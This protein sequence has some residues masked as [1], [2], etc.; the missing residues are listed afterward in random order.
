MRHFDH[1]YAMT[2]HS[3]QGITTDRVLINVDTKSSADL[4]G[5]RFAYVAV[6]RASQDAQV[7]TNDAADVGQRL[8]REASNSSAVEFGRP[9][10]PE[11]HTDLAI[12]L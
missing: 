7:F 2:S 3:A 6:S 11:K 1:G 12:S 5:T 8:S 10:V 9:A 4:V